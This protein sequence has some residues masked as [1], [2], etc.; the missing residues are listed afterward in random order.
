MSNWIKDEV[1]ILVN[2]NPETGNNNVTE[3]GSFFSI[4]LEDDGLRIPRDAR[5]CTIQVENASIWYTTPNIIQGK[6]SK[7][8][9]SGPDFNDVLQNFVVDIPQGLYSSDNLIQTIEQELLRLGAK[10]EANGKSLPLLDFIPDLPTGKIKLKINYPNVTI[11]FTQPDTFRDIL[12]FNSQIIGDFIGQIVPVFVTADFPARFNQIDYYLINSTLTNEGLRINNRY[13]NT[14]ARVLIDVEPGAQIVYSPN[15]PSTIRAD[16]LIGTHLNTFDMI[17]T[18]DRNE[19]VS[20]QG[21]YWSALI[22]I[23]W[24]IKV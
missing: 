4:R 15:H 14:L 19:R 10:V 5:N 21:E 22:K 13:T 16:H 12:G 18:D 1:T 11:D 23:S 6:N 9:I 20:T 8:Y 2:S 3:D 17:L 24:F 7:F